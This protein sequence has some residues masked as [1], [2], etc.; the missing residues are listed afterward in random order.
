[1]GIDDVHLVVA[2]QLT[3]TPQPRKAQ[4]AVRQSNP[5]REAND[6][7]PV[8]MLDAPRPALLFRRDHDHVQVAARQACLRDI[9][10]VG[11]QAPDLRCKV[12]GHDGN[13]ASPRW[14]ALR[15][16]ST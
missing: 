9:E 12:R 14:T 13:Y 1:M 15:S 6:G 10:R 2:E 7:Q 4:R 16:A 3:N 11:F 8:M 5:A